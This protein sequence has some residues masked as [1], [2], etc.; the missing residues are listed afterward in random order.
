[1]TEGET[2]IKKFPKCPIGGLWLTC[3]TFE[4]WRVDTADKLQAKIDK[5]A[6][7]NLETTI[8]PTQV[9]INFLKELLEALK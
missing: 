8:L 6:E 3:K 5:L 1:M 4:K 7:Y 2:A 9:Y